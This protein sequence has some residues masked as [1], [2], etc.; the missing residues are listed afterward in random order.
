MQEVQTHYLKA[1]LQPSQRA[2]I[3]QH[4]ALVHAREDVKKIKQLSSLFK[5]MGEN[6]DQVGIELYHRTE[7]YAAAA[8]PL[9]PSRSLGGAGGR[10]FYWQV[11]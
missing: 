1:I 8:A 6:W 9:R 4:E 5:V 2:L 3:K 7:G 10:D 11:R